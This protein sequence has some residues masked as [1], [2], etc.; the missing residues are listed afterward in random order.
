MKVNSVTES[1]VMYSFC[2]IFSVD[3]TT[4]VNMKINGLT[5]ST[6]M[7]RFCVLY[8]VYSRWEIL[9]NRCQ[10]FGET[11]CLH[12]QGTPN[13]EGNLMSSIVYT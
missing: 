6:V 5:G 12:L 11:C 8:I 7:Y 3:G 4:T 2:Y 13:P 1:C 10:R 9:I